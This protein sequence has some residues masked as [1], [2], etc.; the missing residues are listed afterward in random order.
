[1]IPYQLDWLVYILIALV[2]IGLLGGSIFY[3]WHRWKERK[4]E[5]KQKA[6]LTTPVDWLLEMKMAAEKGEY[7]IAIRKCFHY[8][9]HVLNQREQV[10]LPQVKTNGEYQQI[11]IE[12]HPDLA[13]PFIRLSKTFDKVW[14]GKAPVAKQDYTTYR[15]Q[16]FTLIGKEESDE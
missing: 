2:F 12:K 9:L 7:R 11:L 13:K 5:K 6:M 14:Y 8:L 3:F 10:H 16:V 4:T 15:K 1:M